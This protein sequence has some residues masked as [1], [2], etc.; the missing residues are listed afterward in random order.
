MW[1]VSQALLFSTE[2][3]SRPQA[4]VP[5]LAH[6]KRL[7]ALHNTRKSTG[8]FP[9]YEYGFKRGF[10]LEDKEKAVGDVEKRLLGRYAEPEYELTRIEQMNGG[11][12]E[13]LLVAQ[14]EAAA[15]RLR[16][17]REKNGPVPA[18]TVPDSTTGRKM[19]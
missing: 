13:R 16:A 4:R 2:I 1:K 3:N 19:A 5:T 11:A 9:L 7:I 15:A 17:A 14:A 8:N 6:R 18:E 12:Y 10:G